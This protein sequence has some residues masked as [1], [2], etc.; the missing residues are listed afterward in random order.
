MGLDPHALYSRR[1]TL[2]HRHVGSHRHVRTHGTD[3][4]PNCT[5]HLMA[6]SAMG[7]QTILEPHR[8][9]PAQQA[10]VDCS[11]AVNYWS[12]PGRSGFQHAVALFPAML[13][14][15]VVAHGI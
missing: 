2:R 14:R 11:H 13:A 9:P 6:L 12:G 10:V 7:Y 15:H 3:Q 1:H 5:L 8:R 4:R